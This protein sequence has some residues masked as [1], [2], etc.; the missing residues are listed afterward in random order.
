MSIGEQLLLTGSQRLVLPNKAII[1]KDTFGSV[2]RLWVFVV[3]GDYIPIT[4]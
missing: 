1:L 2:G 4:S 3:S